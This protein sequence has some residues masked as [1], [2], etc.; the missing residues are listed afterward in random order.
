MITVTFSA[1]DYRPFPRRAQCTR[2]ASRT[3]TLHPPAQALALRAARIRKQT[4][5]FRVISAQRAGGE[6]THSQGV[7]NCGL[8]RSRY[9]GEPKTH[10]QHS[11]SAVDINLLRINTWLNGTPLAPTRQSPFARLMTQAA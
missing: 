1:H 4:D 10:L 7:R 11:V 5:A 3:L 6:G 9:I 2:C 8:R